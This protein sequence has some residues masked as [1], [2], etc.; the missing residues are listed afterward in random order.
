MEEQ[1]KIIEDKIAEIKKDPTKFVE[2]VV[3]QLE[4]TLETF[5]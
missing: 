3:A 2:E 5:K 1:I 4:K